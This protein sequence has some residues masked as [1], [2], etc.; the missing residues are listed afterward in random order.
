MSD[1]LIPE[2]ALDLLDTDGYMRRFYTLVQEQ[3]GDMEEAFRIVEGEYRASFRRKRYSN[4]KSF[5]V[6]RDRWLKVYVPPA[7]T[8]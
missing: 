3:D 7:L 6:I 1:I 4:F 5:R 2:S 8:H